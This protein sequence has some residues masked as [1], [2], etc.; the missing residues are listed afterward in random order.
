MNRK[1]KCSRTDQKTGDK[2][3]SAKRRDWN[4]FFEAMRGVK[5]PDDFLSRRSVTRASMIAIRSRAGLSDAGLT[6]AL[7][8]PI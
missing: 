1:A 6:M 4:G 5:V 2:I 8:R 3:H 7:P